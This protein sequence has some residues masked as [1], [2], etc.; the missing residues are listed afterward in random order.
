VLSL[1]WGSSFILIKRGLVG[2]TAVQVGSFRIIFAA[3]FLLIVGFKSLKKISRHQ[4]N[5]L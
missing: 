2:L 4:W 3:L 5:L 1:I